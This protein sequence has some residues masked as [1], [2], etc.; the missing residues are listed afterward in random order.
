MGCRFKKQQNYL[1]VSEIMPIFATSELD[2]DCSS[3]RVGGRNAIPGAA[4]AGSKPLS[5]L[6]HFKAIF[7]LR[8]ASLQAERGWLLFFV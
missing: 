7:L 2:S 6:L 5:T 1:E 3:I 8:Q 4:K